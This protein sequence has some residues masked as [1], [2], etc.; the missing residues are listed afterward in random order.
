MSATHAPADTP[1]K[2]QHISIF[3]EEYQ[4]P[5]LHKPGAF[6]CIYGIGIQ[7]CNRIRSIDHNST[8]TT[9]EERIAID[10]L[11]PALLNRRFALGLDI[12]YMAM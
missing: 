12:F 7:R 8:K 11:M 10:Q 9:D 1:M 5:D 2:L 4:L 6:R 3:D